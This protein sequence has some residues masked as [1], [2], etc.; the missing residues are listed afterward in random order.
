MD[1][2]DLDKNV[3][4]FVA[5]IDN[6]SKTYLATLILPTS[7]IIPGEQYNFRVNLG[8]DIT[9]PELFFSVTMQKNLAL[10]KRFLDM[11]PST[12]VVEVPNSLIG[13]ARFSTL[14]F[15]LYFRALYFC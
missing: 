6:A 14:A 12:N 3:G 11:S 5:L 4:L 10:Q 9:P 7:E 1:K 13:L 8:E 2:S 15:C